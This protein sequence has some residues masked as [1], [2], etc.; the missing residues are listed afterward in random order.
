M[1]RLFVGT[2]IEES[3]RKLLLE[4]K[5][6]N[7]HLDARWQRKLRWVQPEKQHLTWLFIGDVPKEKVMDVEQKLALAVEMFSKSLTPDTP[8]SFSQLTFANAELWP[9]PRKCRQLVLCAK[10]FSPL[11]TSI[12]NEIT[13]ALKQ[14]CD[15][16][17]KHYDTFKPHI[18]LFRLDAP[19]SKEAEKP[20][21]EHVNG[22]STA[23]P[24]DLDVRRISL[25]ESD[26]GKSNEYI[27]LKD[28]AI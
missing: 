23:L 24:F 15:P 4:L 16:D 26:L 8:S 6:A 12:A 19:K 1:T 21:V 27:N 7:C 2:F 28:F 14:F 10:S 18:T 22:L 20:A 3:H 5:Q 25:I 17:A 13:R 11:I 9:N